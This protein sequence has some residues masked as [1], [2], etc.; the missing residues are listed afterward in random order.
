MQQSCLSLS[1]PSI[2]PCCAIH[3]VCCNSPLT[4]LTQ[5]SHYSVL[6]DSDRLLHI[7][8]TDKYSVMKTDP[9]LMAPNG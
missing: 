8:E 1:S 9:N 7:W 3:W 6:Q 4:I 2:S 5:A